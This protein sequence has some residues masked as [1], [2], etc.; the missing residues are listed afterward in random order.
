MSKSAFII[1]LVIL[2]AAALYGGYLYG[3]KRGYDRGFSAAKVEAEA[4]AKKAAEEANP[5]SQKQT[6]PLE[7][8]ETNPYDK[9]QFNPFK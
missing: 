3:N 8:V 6:N 4:A 1:L 5:F 7:K 9:I 2:S